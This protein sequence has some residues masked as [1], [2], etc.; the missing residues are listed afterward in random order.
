MTR[1]APGGAVDA[2][3]L[4]LAHDPLAPALVVSGAPTT[5][6]IALD[7]S[8]AGEIGVWEHTPGTSTDVESDEVFVVLS[9]SA[10]LSFDEPPLPSIELRPGML[11]RLTAGMR[12]VW[13]V[14]DTLRKVY[15][16]PR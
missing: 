3:S 7:E 2:A 9:G 1:I 5:G 13:T 10:T 6:W 12:T 11:V 16:A 15:A 8:D 4:P 14:R